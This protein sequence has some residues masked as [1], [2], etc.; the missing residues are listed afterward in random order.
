MSDIDTCRVC[1]FRSAT[2]PWGSDGRQPSF[3]ICPSCG[4]EWGYEDGSPESARRYRAQWLADGAP[5]A[6]DEWPRDG[7]TTDERLANVP[8][9]FE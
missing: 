8:T 5:W 1:G 9:G 2:P 3:E 7:L 4:V 6:D